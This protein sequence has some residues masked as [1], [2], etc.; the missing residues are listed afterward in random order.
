M[1]G[2]HIGWIEGILG[3]FTSRKQ[4]VEEQL[5]QDAA[6]ANAREGRLFEALL[7]S[8]DPEIRAMAA[9]GLMETTQTPKRKGGFSGW[10]GEMQRHPAYGSMLALMKTPTTETTVTPG[11][12]AKEPQGLNLPQRTLQPAIMAPE[13]LDASMPETAVTSPNAPPPKPL[14]TITVPGPAIGRTDTVSTPR[15]I[16]PTPEYTMRQTT[17][18]KSQADIEGEVAGYV[19]AGFSPEEAKQLVHERIQRARGGTGFQHVSVELPDGTQRAASYSPVTGQYLD[20]DTLQPLPGARPL[21]RSA[22]TSLGVE[23]ESVAREIF[24]KQAA[25]LKPEEM[26]RLNQI[27]WDR[28]ARIL[29]AQ[30]L[31]R[32]SQLFQGRT[33]VTFGDYLDAADA[34][35]QAQGATLPGAPP[36][37][38]STAPAPAGALSASGGAGGQPPTGSAAPEAPGAAAAPSQPPTP[39]S[40]RGK[41]QA[42][43][44]ESGKDLIDTGKPM[45]PAAAQLVG[46]TEANN[47]LIDQALAELKAGGWDKKDTPQ[48]SLD[49]VKDY[50]LGTLSKAVGALEEMGSPAQLADLA[51]LQ[52]ANAPA[53]TQN[54]ARAMQ[55]FV[56]K[57]QHVPR[58]PGGRQV[59][60]NRILPASVLQDA[61]IMIQGDEGAFD[62]PALM[63]E[64]LTKARENNLNFLTAIQSAYTRPATTAG[65]SSAPTGAPTAV[66]DAH[67]NWIIKQ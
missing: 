36:V 55:Y 63:V 24:G 61:S 7:A 1:E 22:S 6:D 47:K 58:L 2:S 54:A 66:K 5:R 43:M 52:T 10:I 30:V 29:P 67:G 40:L 57:R 60:F 50:R 62:S 59:L 31:A 23:R 51:G 3:G 17:L 20:P 37:P 25:A 16:F 8:P 14:S 34:L 32:V 46:R 56:A 65:S 19:A 4:Q 21:S 45:P 44:P 64:K 38:S 41:V 15:Q 9:T 18:A 12:T 26:A 53:L 42:A 49:M 48:D 13:G 28:K 39:T 27:L 11:L 35:M 33:D